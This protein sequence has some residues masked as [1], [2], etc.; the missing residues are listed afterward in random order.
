MR[1]VGR[2][3][4]AFAYQGTGARLV[5]ALKFRDGRRLVAPLADQLVSVLPP[6]HLADGGVVSWIPT[7]AGR[8]R[9]RGFDQAELLARALARRLGVRCRPTLRRVPGPAQTGQDRDHRQTNVH[10]EPIGPTSAAVLLVDDVC[11]TGATARAAAEALAPRVA[12]PV[13]IVVVA[14]TP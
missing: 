3:P 8:R 14:R 6:T 11:T 10:F 13:R 5:Q 2:V 1:G 4:A 12:G 9:S 7:S